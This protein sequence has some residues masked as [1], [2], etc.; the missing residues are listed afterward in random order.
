MRDNLR[1]YRAR[2][3]A[4]VPCYPTASR[5]N[6]ARHLNTLA[7]L[8]SG[9]VGSKSTPLPHLATKVPDG[10][11]PERRVKR[12]ARWCANAHILE[13]VYLLPSVEVLRR[14]RALETVGLVMDGRG[15]G[16]GCPALM[17]PVVSKG[18][19]LPLAWRVRQAPQGHVPAELPIA[20]VALRREVIPA[21][22]QGVG[23]GDGACD[24][25]ARQ[26]TRHEAG[27]ADACRT[28]TRTT[29]TW[30]GTPWRLDTLGACRKPGRLS[31]GKNVHGTREAYGPIMGRCCGAQG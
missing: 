4:L 9:L 17:R 29:A 3:H 15:V 13:E 21:G 1:R 11:K 27:W 12:F 20:M 22:A 8:L 18:R 23:L 28:A 26:A 31:E 24:G 5:G 7:A 25:T 6:V 14:P 2:R 10:T 30:D 19:A 16:R